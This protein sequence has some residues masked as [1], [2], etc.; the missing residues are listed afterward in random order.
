MNLS[1]NVM[2]KLLRCRLH[3]MPWKRCASALDLER[4]NGELERLL[5]H[6]D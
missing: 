5:Q 1:V 3:R 4:R 6:K 2:S